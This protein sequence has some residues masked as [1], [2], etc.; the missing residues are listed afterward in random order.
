VLT[1]CYGAFIAGRLGLLDGL[2]A[3]TWYGSVTQLG[4]EFPTAHALAGRR[5][6]DNGKVVTT[7][8]VSAGIDGS[9]HLVART[10]GRY[11][12]DR[13][14]EYMEYAWTPQ[15]YSTSKYA[16]LNPRL[17][18]HGRRLQEASIAA[19]A[20]DSESAVA[21]VRELI[22]KDANDGA[23]WLQLGRLMLAT[24]KYSDAIAAYSEAAKGAAQR[25]TALYDLACSYALSGE[26]EKAIDAA[27]RAIDAGMRVKAAYQR[28]PDLASI[29]EDPRFQQLITNL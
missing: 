1:I 13:V 6:I 5:F 8:G 15:S 11:V 3:T 22:A 25:A 10:L 19:K 12:A 26:K 18:A 23:A 16:Q 2:D 20:G 7:A 17:D 28:D 21:I 24:K 14:A 29:R 4:T 9:L 27:G